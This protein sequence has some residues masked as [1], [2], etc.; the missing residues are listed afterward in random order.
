V[1]HYD[2]PDTY[3]QVEQRE[4]RAIRYGGQPHVEVYKMMSRTPFDFSN[5]TRLT[6]KELLAQSVGNPTDYVDD[7]VTSKRIRDMRKASEQRAAADNDE[8]GQ[9]VNARMKATFEGAA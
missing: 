3:A 8:L 1:F 9:M 4:G 5:D 2:L 6:V 7:T